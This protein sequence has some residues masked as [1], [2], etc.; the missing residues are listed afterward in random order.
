MAKG[1]V[2]FVRL[3]T[4]ICEEE[5]I[6]CQGFSDNWAFKL[7]DGNR[8]IYIVGYHFPENRGSSRELCQDKCLT[9]EVLFDAGVPACPHFFLPDPKVGN[10]N[11]YLKSHH[12]LEEYL[13][14]GKEIVLKDNYGT[15]GK[16]VYRTKDSEEAE[17][18]LSDIFQTGYGASVSPFY[19]IKEEYRIILLKGEPLLTIRK[20]RESFLNEKGEKEYKT[21]KHNLGQGATG[22]PVTESSVLKMLH[23][24]AKKAAST[25]DIDFA[26]VDIIDTEE[27]LMVLEVNAGVMMEHFSGQNEECYKKAKEIYRKAIRF[28]F[29]KEES[30]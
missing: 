6:F 12:I 13:S 4:E 20:E 21:W 8:H 19:D 18:I 17:K 27:G 3:I 5:N 16:A 23:P 1:R 7:S 26:S 28:A 10:E 9:Y 29:Q 11:Q 30:K 22:I 14:E 2:N 24:L 15:G 25:L